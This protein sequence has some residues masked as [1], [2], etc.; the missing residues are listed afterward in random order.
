MGD[1]PAGIELST[2][3]IPITARTV[4]VGL[5]WSRVLPLYA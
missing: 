3:P 5:S 4:E 1:I 2:G